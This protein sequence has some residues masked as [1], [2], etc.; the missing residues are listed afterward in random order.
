MSK[1]G[2][3]KV[4]YPSGSTFEFEGRWLGLIDMGREAVVAIL[5]CTMVEAVVYEGEAV[6]K[7]EKNV[8]LLDPRAVCLLGDFVL[9][10]PRRYD[11]GYLEFS[12]FPRWVTDWL[13]DNPDWPD[14]VLGGRLRIGTAV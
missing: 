1:D 9:Y 12:L 7:P 3:I 4:I 11:Y 13:A 6:P 2:P 10:E 5:D 14:R 8:F